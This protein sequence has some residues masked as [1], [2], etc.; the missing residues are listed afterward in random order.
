[1]YYMCMYKYSPCLSAQF[2][3]SVPLLSALSTT[4]WYPDASSASVLISHLVF[5]DAVGP[6]YHYWFHPPTCLAV[7]FLPSQ[8]HEASLLLPLCALCSQ[9]ARRACKIPTRSRLHGEDLKYQWAK[10]EFT[11][12]LLWYLLAWIHC[13]QK[14]RCGHGMCVERSAGEPFSSSWVTGNA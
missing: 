2:P 1:M 12:L 7:Q 5:S 10:G 6:K 11:V 4:L 3:S 9:S 8:L 13:S 14:P